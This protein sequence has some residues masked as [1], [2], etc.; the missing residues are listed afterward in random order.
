MNRT[1]PNR[2]TPWGMSD[3][4]TQ[5]APGIIFYSTPSHGGFH[6]SADR[7]KVFSSGTLA[8]TWQGLGVQGWFEEDCDA[9]LVVTTFPYLFTPA[10]V[11][12]AAAILRGRAAIANATA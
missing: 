4:A 6:L 1:A 12:N 9:A 3:L 11:N 10:E 7:L 8:W 5:I 2:D